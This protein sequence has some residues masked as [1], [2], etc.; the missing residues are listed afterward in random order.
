MSRKYN[1]NDNCMDILMCWLVASMNMRHFSTLNMWDSYTSIF[2]KEN[3]HS[4]FDSKVNNTFGIYINNTIQGN[5][6]SLLLKK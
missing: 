4:I 6:T 2:E 1:S 5:N 3:K